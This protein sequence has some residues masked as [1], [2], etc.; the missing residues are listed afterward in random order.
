MLE[1]KALGSFNLKIDI[2]LQLEY[3][4]KRNTVTF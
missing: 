3:E 2:D 4:F 1:Q